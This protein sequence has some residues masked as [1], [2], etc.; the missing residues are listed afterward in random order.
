MGKIAHMTN[1]ASMYLSIY[2]F[3][4]PRSIFWETHLLDTTGCPSVAITLTILLVDIY[5]GTTY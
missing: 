1:I 2:F 5:S 4:D 3:D